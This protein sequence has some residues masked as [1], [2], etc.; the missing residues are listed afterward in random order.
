[1][2]VLV[3][4]SS[5]LVGSALLPRLRAAGHRVVCLVRR[6]TK[7]NEFR[8]YPDKGVLQAHQLHG[9]DGVVH[10]AGEGIADGRW[11][12]AKKL[13][14]RE[15]RTKP[16]LLLAETLAQLE[17]RPKAFVGASAIGFYGN[18]GDEVLTEASSPG[19]GFLAGVCKEW[20]AA[21]SPLAQ[22]GVRV[23]NLRIGIVLSSVGGA[24][25]KMLLPF[26]LG[27]AGN[28]GNGR[29]YYS[30]ITLH[31]LVSA[32]I[33]ALEN[34]SLQGP[35][36]AVAPQSVPNAVFTKALGRVLSRPT[37]FPM[38]AF[39]A[40]LVMGEMA[41]ELLLASTRVVPEK[42]KNAG[43]AFRHEDIDSALKHCI[44]ERQ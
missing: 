7:E 41:D 31:D 28:V 20:E 14:L 2:N 23:V 5:G 38:P 17:D 36:N 44:Q 9:I 4:G 34:D 16:T 10:L 30:W 1:M 24:L 18:R 3:T 21:T 43:F 6:V 32:I 40:R 26:R 27:I 13:R 29:Q 22:A 35:V 15:T 12:A 33:F 11:T 42:L 19:T 8:W 37:I 25:A 39:A